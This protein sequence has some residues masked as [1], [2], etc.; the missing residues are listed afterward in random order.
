VRK[1][2]ERRDQ[3]ESP[4]EHGS[5]RRKKPGQSR[6]QNL[7]LLTHQIANHIHSSVPVIEEVYVWLCSQI[8][9]PVDE[10]WVAS[11]QVVL[12]PDASLGDVRPAID[13]IINDELDGIPTFCERLSRGELPL[14]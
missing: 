5:R 6:R 14:C 11:A 13:R 2:R 12:K 4:D 10:P 1:S 7:Q 9:H 3:S 8:G